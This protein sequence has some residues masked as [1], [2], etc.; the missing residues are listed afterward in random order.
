MKDRKL[1]N[2]KNRPLSRAN[3]GLVVV[4]IQDR[5]LPQIFEKE[6]LVQNTLLLIKGLAVLRVPMLVTEQYRKGLGLTAPEVASAIA[7]FSPLDKVT[8]SA[9]GAEGF[10]NALK[11]K[12]IS[13]IILCGM[14]SH[15]CVLQTGLDLLDEGFNDE[16][17]GS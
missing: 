12:G 4:D 16:G 3:A 5:L 15:I 9:C 6:R 2:T 14:E 10:Q 13:D 17:V 1:N 11:A 7:N 8:F